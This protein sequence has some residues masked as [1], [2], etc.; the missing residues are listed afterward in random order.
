MAPRIG[1]C[2]RPASGSWRAGRKPARC[3]TSPHGP[4]GLGFDSVWVG[5]SLL[6]RPRHDPLTLLAAVVARTRKVQLGTAVF[7]PA[8]RNPVVLAHQLATLDQISEGRLVLGAGIAS[9]VPNIRAEFV[10][11]GVPFEGRVGRM[12]EGLR[13][14]RAL[15]AGKPVDWDGRWQVEGGVLGPTP[16]RQ[17]GPPIWLAGSVR[18]A[19]ERAA[20][21]F[22]GWFANEASLARWAEQWGEVRAIVREAGRD[23]GKFVAAV[24]VTLA[25]GE[26]AG[27][28]EQRLDAFLEN[29]YGQPAAM[30]RRR[31][32]CYAGSAAGAAAFF[33]GFADAGASHVIVRFT[34]DHERNLETFTKLRADLGW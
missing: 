13:L 2:C 22:D 7:L 23:P 6:A 18:P 24:Y 5:D 27:R 9:D 17:G 25:I 4:R 12:M 31:Q 33:K 15:W 10:A 28:A 16:Y 32:A 30:M 19:F 34:G 11:A 29:Y 1:Y 20:R 26:D 21:H 3:S 8:L 14:A